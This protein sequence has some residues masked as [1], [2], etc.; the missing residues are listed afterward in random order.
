MSQPAWQPV[1]SF[2]PDALTASQ[3]GVWETDFE[4]DSTR[5]DATCAA[6]FGVDPV[7]AARGLPLAAYVRKVLPEDRQMLD[8]KLTE[9]RN[10][11]GLFVIEYRTKPVP[12]DLRWV[13]ARGRYDRNHAT[14]H[15][16]G[17]GIIIDITESKLDGQV[18]DR[19]LFVAP[20]E[21]S[22]SLDRLA[23][24]ALEARQE[25]DDLGEKEGSPLRRVVD[26]FLWAVGQ[27]LAKARGTLNPTKRDLN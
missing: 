3:V 18:E 11:G 15:M 12:D 8:D 22:P 13:L 4:N 24:I 1:L 21:V 6:I 5:V 17:R 7:A 16:R 2:V 20:A 14:G 26:A 19:A 10:V 23:A 9:V 27:A 25:V